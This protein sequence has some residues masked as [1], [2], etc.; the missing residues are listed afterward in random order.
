MQKVFVFVVVVNKIAIVAILAY[1]R[2]NIVKNY[3]MTN[4]FCKKDQ[5]SI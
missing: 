1:H 5:I 3:Q 2:A 4:F